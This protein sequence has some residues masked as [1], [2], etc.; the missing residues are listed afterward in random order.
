MN[1][2]LTNG[3]TV[4]ETQNN[5]TNCPYYMYL[6][7]SA[8]TCLPT[9]YARILNNICCPSTAPLVASAGSQVCIN[10]CPANI[11]I[12]NGTVNQ[13]NATCAQ[14]FG[15]STTS[16]GSP[17]AYKCMACATF[18]QRN[19][20][21]CVATC[22][23]QNATT[24]NS[25]AITICEVANSS[26]CLYYTRKDTAN[27]TCM[28]A[29]NST[30]PFNFSKLCVSTCKNESSKFLATDGINCAATCSVGY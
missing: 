9:C 3:N 24:I 20:S 11:Y 26:T 19:D 17:A 12:M 27:F 22:S 28:A 15:I 4:C 5:A 30:Y 23:Y 6:N 10:S 21:K 29:C 13:C 18:I 25:T 16:L 1:A 14:P 7:A 2:T 8:F